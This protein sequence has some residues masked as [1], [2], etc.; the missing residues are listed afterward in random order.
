MRGLPLES[1]FARG[2]AGSPGPG[3][4][5][6]VE[7]LL[8]SSIEVSHST[9]RATI[10]GWG[11]LVPKNKSRPTPPKPLRIPRPSDNT[12]QTRKRRSPKADLVRFF[13]AGRVIYT[14]K[15]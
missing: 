13:G 12:G 10:A 1:A 4:W 9:L 5:H 6:T 7:E 2:A 15:E 14:P 8:A 11:S 3:S